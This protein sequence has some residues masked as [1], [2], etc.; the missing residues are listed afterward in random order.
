MEAEKMV[1]SE[2]GEESQGPQRRVYNIT[3]RG[4]AHLSQWVDDLRRTRR[5]IDALLAAF[6]ET[7]Q[8]NT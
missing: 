3:P 4:E 5:E 2:W 7:V 8:V 1:V 6:Q